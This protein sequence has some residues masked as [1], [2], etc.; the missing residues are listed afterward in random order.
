MRIGIITGEYPPQKGGI[1]S[2][3]WHL[4]PHLVQAGHDV[5]LLTS[6]ACQDNRHY[7]RLDNKV[8]RWHRKTWQD[9]QKWATEH[10]LDVVNLHYQTAIY[11]M[12][13][14]VHFLPR[15]LDYC[16]LVTT[17]HDLLPPYLFPKAGQIRHWVVRE[18]ARTSQA[19]IVSNHQ[20]AAQLE[21]LQYVHTIPIA[22][23]IL[24]IEQ[25][26]QQIQHQRSL[27][28]VP[29]E[30]FLIGHFGFL[31]PNRGVEYLLHALHALKEK[32]IPVRLLMLGGRDSG[33]TNQAYVAQL[34]RLISTLG[35]ENIVQWTGYQD[36][37]TI[38]QTLQACDL[39]ALP[40][41]DGAS[42][43]RTSLIAAIQN[44]CPIISTTIAPESPT[45][46]HRVNMSLVPPANILAL[47]NELAYL[48]D[49]A[50]QRRKYRQACKDMRPMFAWDAITHDILRVFEEVKRNV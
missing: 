5:F 8:T 39:I 47:T 48:Y 27:V 20:D 25:T 38:S 35:L 41:L 50:E 36:N 31:Y 6:T 33:P 24:P 28:N 11:N 49:N 12:S 4:M 46:K 30:D 7:V 13:A 32:Q 22:S 16:P 29:K 9:V 1:A 21:H 2:Y 37:A 44:A 19:V 3:L 18:L 17:F 42:Y 10:Q 34:D 45:L 26:P 14:S 15:W 43:R 23:D 40:F